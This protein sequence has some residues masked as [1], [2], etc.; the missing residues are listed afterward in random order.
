MHSAVLLAKEN[1]DLRAA[2]EKEKE[3]RKQSRRQMT[4]NKGLCIQ[5]ARDLIQTRNKQGNEIKGSS[6][7]SAP[8]PLEPLKHAPLRCS[9]CLHYR[10]Y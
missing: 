5:E 10:A 4:P 2:N 7:D 3:K 9:N 6:I 1:H 8:L